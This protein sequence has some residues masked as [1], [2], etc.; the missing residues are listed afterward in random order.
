MKTENENLNEYNL[1]HENTI[2]FLDFMSRTREIMKKQIR[3]IFTKSEMI[4]LVSMFNGTIVQAEYSDSNS[5][6][7]FQI[8]EHEEY[9]KIS[10]MYNVNV[11][12]LIGKV[13]NLSDL[14]TLYLCLECY[15]FWYEREDYGKS[16]NLGEFIECMTMSKREKLNLKIKKIKSHSDPD[17]SN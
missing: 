4:A 5:N 6:L 8:N 14:Q 11:G 13:R 16:K 15:M 2:T 17:I 3:P 7:E 12:D 10:L 9:N 1:N